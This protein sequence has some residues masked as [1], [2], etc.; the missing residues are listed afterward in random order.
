MVWIFP[1]GEDPWLTTNAFERR[2]SGIQSMLRSMDGAKASQN[3]G[4][5]KLQEPEP[6]SA[7]H[8]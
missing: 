4:S 3:K 1:G 2:V 6:A 5:T 7:T 8:M